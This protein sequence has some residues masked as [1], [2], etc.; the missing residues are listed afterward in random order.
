MTEE[1]YDSEFPR[2]ADGSRLLWAGQHLEVRAAG[3]WEYV[4]RRIRRPAV[5]IVAITDRN[6]MVLIE[7]LRPPI[8]EPV[9]EIP[10]G[11]VGDLAGHSD[12]PL[13]VAAR[14]ELLEE[15]GY[16]ASHW[17]RLTEGCSS[18]GLTDE[19]VVLYLA[20]GLQKVAAGGGDESE[21]IE[22]HL[23]PVV[24]VLTWIRQR[25]APIDLKVLAALALL[26]EIDLS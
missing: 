8:G 13:L 26:N 12:E 21:S 25:G 23:V 6:E 1:K 19:S 7:Q 22:T 14:R 9:I 20:R 18:P 4:T 17:T 2:V 15:T 16:E 3:T 10:A 5:A 24:E 11:L